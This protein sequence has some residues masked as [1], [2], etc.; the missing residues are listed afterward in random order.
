MDLLRKKILESRAKVRLVE[1]KPGIGKTW[2][3]CELAQHELTNPDLG[4]QTHQKILFLTF[5]R[6]AVARIR[7]VFT[8]QTSLDESK[9]KEL[10]KRLRIDTFAGF[11]WWLVESYGRY[12]KNGTTMR[13]WLLGSKEVV[14][15]PVPAGH[16]GYTFEKLEAKAMEVIRIQAVRWLIC[17]IY[18]LVIID[19]FQDVHDRLFEIIDALG[20]NSR[21]VL[22]SGP[23]QC[24][25]RGLPGKEFDP[26]RIRQKCIMQLGTVPFDLPSL[27]EEKQRYCPEIKELISQFDRGAVAV[28]PDWP[29]KLVAVERIILK[30]ALE[31]CAGTLANEM[32]AF[33]KKIGTTKPEIAILSSTNQGVAEIYARVTKGHGGLQI[34]GEF[35]KLKSRSASL[36]FGDNVFLQYG[37]LML[38]LLKTHW[39]A[40][41]KKEIKSKEVAVLIA[42]LF[43][44]QDKNIEAGSGAWEDLAQLLIRKANGQC[45]ASGWEERL[46][47]NL[48]TLNKLLRATQ[49]EMREEGINDCPSTAFDKRDSGFLETLADEFIESI[50]NNV[51]TRGRL[52]IEKAGISFE[53][54]N[55]QKVIFEKLG[56]QKSVQVMTIHKSKGREFDGVVLVL[57]DN[58]KALWKKDGPAS[59]PEIDDLYRVAISRA[60]SAFALVAFEDARK[61]AAEPVKRLLPC[62]IRGGAFQND[63]GN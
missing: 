52:D 37:R 43:Q 32:R 27:G 49:A 8:K 29:V 38:Q 36:L 21:L 20:K 63:M 23:G 15:A 11:F 19:E 16:Q 53:K 1:G 62:K 4:V 33:L 48:S 13:L 6:N 2:F 3:G 34:N 10:A 51:N 22:L 54:A 30:Y 45:S 47:T 14:D 25:Y 28:F 55:Q 35:K 5:A 9:K 40:G 57:E 26:D 39:I 58:H 61:E 60:R 41:N 56:I 59:G 7:Q 18:P 42:M 50:K 17:D 44:E 46:K 31:V 24:I 12:T